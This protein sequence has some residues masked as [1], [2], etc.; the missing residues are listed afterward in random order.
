MRTRHR[1]VEVMTGLAR[2]L[3]NDGST[4]DVLIITSCNVSSDI[5]YQYDPVYVKKEIASCG[6]IVKSAS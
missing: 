4:W 2:R 3:M 6:C 5:S 1:Y